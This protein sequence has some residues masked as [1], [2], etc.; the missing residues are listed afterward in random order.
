[1]CHLIGVQHHHAHVLSAIA[2]HRLEGPVLGFAW[3]G[4]GYG[5]DGTILGLRGDSCRG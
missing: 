5:L 2:E 4:T 1:M 3:D